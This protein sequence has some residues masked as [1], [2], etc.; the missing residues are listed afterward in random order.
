MRVGQ[1]VVVVD[2]EK[3][4]VVMHEEVVVVVDALVAVVHEQT[5]AHVQ[6][7]IHHSRTKHCTGKA[8]DHSVHAC[9]H[10][11]KLFCPTHRRKSY[12]HGRHDP[13]RH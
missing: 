12:R 11:P 6:A 1:E 10:E 13:N 4:V 3:E 9:T 7:Q 5:H 2:E 8:I